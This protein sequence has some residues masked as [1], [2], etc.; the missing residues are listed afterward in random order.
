MYKKILF[1][2][3]MLAPLSL[4]ADISKGE[5]LE[6]HRWELIKRHDWK[7]LD[8]LTA[9]YFQLSL[10]D[11]TRNKEQAMNL[12]LSSEISDYTLS[13]FVVT[14][15]PGI[16]VVTYQ[17]NLSETIEGL[18]E[19]SKANRL[20]IWQNNHGKWQNIALAI[21]IPVPAPSPKK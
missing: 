17:I 6:R 5:S 20:S 14:E 7:A 4:F 1:F 8:D 2:V 19:S 16:I 3:A 15:G 9:P 21:L 18:R 11:G 13:D 10:F 12:A